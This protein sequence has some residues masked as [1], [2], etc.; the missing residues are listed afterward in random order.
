MPSLSPRS[1]LSEDD[2]NETASQARLTGSF[3]LYMGCSGVLAAVALL[4]NSVPIL[5]GGAS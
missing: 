2:I 4:S 5:I 1:M 3:A